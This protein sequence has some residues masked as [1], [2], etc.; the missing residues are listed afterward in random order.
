MKDPRVRSVQPPLGLTVLALLAPFLT[1]PLFL[2]LVGWLRGSGSQGGFE[3][4]WR[5]VGTLIIAVGLGLITGVLLAIA[6]LKRGERHRSLGWFAL[7]LNALPLILLVGWPMS[8]LLLGA[9]DN[10]QVVPRPI[11]AAYPESTAARGASEQPLPR[12][13]ALAEALPSGTLLYSAT[14]AGEIR[15]LAPDGSRLPPLAVELDGPHDLDLDSG[16]GR[17]Y[18]AQWDRPVVYSLDLAAGELREVYAGSGA[19]GQGIGVDAAAGRMFWGEYYGGLY[20][21]SPDGKAPPRRLVSPE[22]LGVCSGG[23]GVGVEVEPEGRQVYFFS[24]DNCN[25]RGRALWRVGYAGEGL[26][27]LRQL[28]SSDCLTLAR[29]DGGWLYF[30]DLRD[31]RFQLWRSRLDG[32]EARWLFDL[33]QPERPCAG[34][35]VDADAE[36]LYFLQSS[37]EPHNVSDLW[38]SDLAGGGLELLDRNIPGG[39]GLLL[40]P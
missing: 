11:F 36:R 32:S 17:L 14:L 21:G 38:R 3:G 28:E 29:Q 34:V 4:T 33:P 10:R 39:Q 7:M 18:I 9:L 6:A 31:G 30:S 23:V 24:R 26:T 13:P 19:G 5:G 8:S 15:R 27:R 35:A 2:A 12:G 25:A 22:D 40:V 16:E 1:T 37:G 20:R